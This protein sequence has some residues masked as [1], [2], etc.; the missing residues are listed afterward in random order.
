M[1]NTLPTLSYNPIGIVWAEDHHNSAYTK[2]GACP[3]TDLEHFEWFET[4][5]NDAITGRIAAQNITTETEY[6]I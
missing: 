3:R 6:N 4:E 2:D 5:I 1:L